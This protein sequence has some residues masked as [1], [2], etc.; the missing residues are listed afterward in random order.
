MPLSATQRHVL[1]MLWRRASASRRA[2]HVRRIKWGPERAAPHMP[3]RLRCREADL[4]MFVSVC[5]RPSMA[6]LTEAQDPTVIET[7]ALQFTEKCRC[8][9]ASS[10][11]EFAIRQ[12]MGVA[13]YLS[14]P[15]LSEVQERAGA[16][17]DGKAS[18]ASCW[19]CL[20]SISSSRCRAESPIS[21]VRTRRATVMFAE[22]TCN[23]RK[24]YLY[25][26][27]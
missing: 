22:T 4:N 13:C 18:R 27:P 7:R 24:R 17:M 20:T 11:T 14:Q 26:F 10:R 9:H 23:V 1:A 16:R 8:Q 5:G 3:K 21:P 6:K 19:R 15:A 12:L 2:R 25:H